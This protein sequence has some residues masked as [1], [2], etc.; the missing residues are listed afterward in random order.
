MEKFLAE[1]KAVKSVV[2]PVDLNTAAVTGAR[3][4]MR[5]AKRVTFIVTLAAGTSTTGHVVTLRQHTAASSGTSADLASENPYY[6][7]VG[8]ATVFTK[9]TPGSAA[10]AKDIHAVVG[11]NASIVIFE[12]LAEELTEGYGWVSVDTSDVGGAQLGSVIALV[13]TDYKPGYALAV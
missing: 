7:K 12:V 2:G 6:H 8:A 9:V 10:A 3:V 5:K 13:E 11:D 1:D 4:D